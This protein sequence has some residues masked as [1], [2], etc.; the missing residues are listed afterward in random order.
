[1][2]ASLSCLCCL[3]PF[4]PPPLSSDDVSVRMH[5]CFVA[6]VRKVL[7]LTARELL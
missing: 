5:A 7:A 4:F 3:V 6:F 1:M 2:G